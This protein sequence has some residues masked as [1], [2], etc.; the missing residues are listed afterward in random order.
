MSSGERDGNLLR[1]EALD[2]ATN[3]KVGVRQ[4]DGVAA[5]VGVERGGEGLER[6]VQGGR[7]TGP[8]DGVSESETCKAGENR[9]P[10]IRHA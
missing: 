6:A 8:D 9:A 7:N 1:F 2:M 3:P 4:I 10:T 5:Q